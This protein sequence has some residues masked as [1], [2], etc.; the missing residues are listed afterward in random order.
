M[1]QQEL[2]YADVIGNTIVEIFTDKND[3]GVDEK[4]IHY[5]AYGYF[6]ACG[7]NPEKDH[8]FIEYTF[9]IVPL[10]EAL[11]FGV[12]KY[13]SEEG[14]NYKQYVA[15]VDENEMV[16]RYKHYDNGNPPR[17]IRKG[18]LNLKT[19]DGFYILI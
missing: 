2:E 6:C 4:Y 15:D 7:G 19:P 8:R 18:D 10:K 11:D 5:Y 1:A 16:D 13:E 9:F 14:C 3:D 17:L 12:E